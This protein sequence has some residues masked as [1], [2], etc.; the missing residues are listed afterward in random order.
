MTTWQLKVLTPKGSDKIEWHR[1]FNNLDGKNKDLHFLP[2]YSLIYEQTYG[3]KGFLAIFGD[4]EDFIILPFMKRPVGNLTFIKESSLA[5][6][7]NLSDIV[8]AY[9]YGGPLAKI[10]HPDVAARLY[11]EF[12]SVFSDYCKNVD[13]IC[14]FASLHPLLKNH[15]PLND[16]KIIEPLQRK[17]IVYFDLNKTEVE[18]WRGLSRGN[19]S[20]INKARQKGVTISREEV[21]G[22][23]LIEFKKLYAETMERQN[24]NQRW[25]FPEDYFSNCAEK[26][27]HDH[28]SLFCAHLNDVIIAEYLILHAYHTAYYHFGGSLEAHFEVR[29]N[30]LLMY[31]IALWAKKQGYRWFHLG[32]GL[33][34]DDSLHK[35]KSGFSK[36][37]TR[38]YTYSRIF[39]NKQ[40]SELCSM[41]NKWDEKEGIISKDT[42]FFP[43]YRS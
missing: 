28:V 3:Q 38:L 27:G 14:E 10:T 23:A 30:N 41:K 21:S 4:D 12:F 26:L 32:G 35:F 33:Q 6:M 15:Q 18:L 24:A 5:D 22:N 29:A 9:G 13:I 8:N 19:Q 39:D 43:A 20:S 7:E 25:I 11:Q 17:K 40:Y 16:Y 31:E 37:E 1:F 36:E 2:E 34:N 42:D